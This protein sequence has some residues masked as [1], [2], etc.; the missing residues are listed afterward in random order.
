MDIP[1]DYTPGWIRPE[2][3]DASFI[4][5]WDELAW[6]RHDGVPRR[7]YYV[8]A[9]DK[10]YSYGLA[11]YARTY[12]SQPMHRELLIIWMGAE[13]L[14]GHGFDTCFLNGYDDGKDHLGWHSDDSPEMDDARPILIV[15]L[16]A[17]REIWFRK[18]PELVAA[19]MEK[20]TNEN[21]GLGPEAYDERKEKLSAIT[22]L[23]LGHGSLCVMKPGMQDTHQHRIPKSSENTC[24]PRISMTF[25]GYVPQ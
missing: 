17:E 9:E 13:A 20:F 19:E 23:K 21:W 8:H 25:R 22:K 7:E 18:R 3:A 15:T 1:I 5:L 14:C 24:G 2:A 6:V 12:E 16:G 10:P 4:R 11:A